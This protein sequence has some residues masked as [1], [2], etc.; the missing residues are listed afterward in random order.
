MGKLFLLPMQ[1]NWFFHSYCHCHLQLI[2]LFLLLLWIIRAAK[3][4]CPYDIAADY[5]TVTGRAQ[6]LLQLSLLVT[7]T[8]FGNIIEQNNLTVS[9]AMSTSAAIILI[10]FHAYLLQS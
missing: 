4:H 10:S 1:I 7:V 3:R 9:V 8:I 2:L 5:V 6:L